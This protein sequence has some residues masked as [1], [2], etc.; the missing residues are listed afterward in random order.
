M[1]KKQNTDNRKAGVGSRKKSS[2]LPNM[3]WLR[4]RRD[5]A[6]ARNRSASEENPLIH[7]LKPSEPENLPPKPT[8]GDAGHSPEKS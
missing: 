2:S 6:P 5:G 8:E 3:E 7:L 4:K 1:A